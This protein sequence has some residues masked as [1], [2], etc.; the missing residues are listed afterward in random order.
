MVQ[1]VCDRGVVKTWC[2]KRERNGSP[3][4]FERQTELWRLRMIDREELVE[5]HREERYCTM[6]ESG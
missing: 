1:S 5:S 2:R 4:L 3:R 6:R